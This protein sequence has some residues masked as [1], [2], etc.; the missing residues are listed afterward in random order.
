M[1]GGDIS[2]LVAPNR[3]GAKTDLQN[4]QSEQEVRKIAQKSY[5]RFLAPNEK[6]KCRDR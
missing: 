3:P 4:H 1:C 5:H 6:P 2:R